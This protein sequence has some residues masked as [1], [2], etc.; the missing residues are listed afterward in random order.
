MQNAG[1][2]FLLRRKREVKTIFILNQIKTFLSCA[3]AHIIVTDFRNT[4]ICSFTVV[5]IRELREDFCL[6]RERMPLPINALMETLNLM[7][8]KWSVARIN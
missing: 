6:C 4:K 5:H 8:S 3:N 2:L 7:W 1:W